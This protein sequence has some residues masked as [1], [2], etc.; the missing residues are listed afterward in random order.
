MYLKIL[1]K[2]FQ[3][4]QEFFRC[5]TAV[6]IEKNDIS[7]SFKGFWNFYKVSVWLANVDLMRCVW[8]PSIPQEDSNA[9]EH[10]KES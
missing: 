5:T 9:Y 2:I 10:A 8:I 1:N 4:T 7:K 6:V 3:F